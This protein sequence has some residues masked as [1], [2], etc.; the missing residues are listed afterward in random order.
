MK[1]LIS[2]LAIVYAAFG[3]L[4]LIIQPRA[5]ELQR[6]EATRTGKD[7]ENRSVVAHLVI[8]PLLLNYYYGGGFDQC[9]GIADS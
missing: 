5:S 8:W 4:L 7:C 3:I 9:L 6:L 2:T 1:G